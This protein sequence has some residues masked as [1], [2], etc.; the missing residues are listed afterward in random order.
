MTMTP[1]ELKALLP[2]TADDGMA[3]HILAACHT[4]GLPLSYGLALVEKE[5]GF[6]NV[7][8]HDPTS[9]IP[10]SWRGSRVTRAKYRVYKAARKRGRGMQG[11]GPV[12]LTWFAFQDQADAVGGCHKPYPN[13]VV[14]FRLLASLINQHGKEAGAGAFNGTGPAAE[15]YGRDWVHKQAAWHGKVS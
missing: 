10:V 4:T 8:G 7:F 3:T 12:Q 14:G 15:A 1:R 2:K 6:R 9:S 11:V 13:L 5:T